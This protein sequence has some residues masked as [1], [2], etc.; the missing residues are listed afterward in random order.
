MRTPT[1]KLSNSLE[2]SKIIHHAE[3]ELFVHSLI[4]AMTREISI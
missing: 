2:A 4:K 3:V 1:V